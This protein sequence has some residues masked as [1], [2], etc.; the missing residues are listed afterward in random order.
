ML[1]KSDAEGWNS[2]LS[3]RNHDWLHDEE[4]AIIHQIWP[5]LESC[6]YWHFTC[7]FQGLKYCSVLTILREEKSKTVNLSDAENF[8]VNLNFR[9]EL[10]RIWSEKFIAWWCLNNDGQ[11]SEIRIFLFIQIISRV[12]IIMSR[13]CSGRF[14]WPRLLSRSRANTY[15]TPGLYTLYTLYTRT[16]RCSVNHPSVGD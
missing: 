5:L 2:F 15:V 16:H 6:L 4:T 13:S 14:H 1:E 8:E 10:C 7:Y 12:C 3:R 11:E 9:L